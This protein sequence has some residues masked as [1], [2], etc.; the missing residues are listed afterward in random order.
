MRYWPVTL[1][2]EAQVSQRESLVR[3]QTIYVKRHAG[4][5]D[6]TIDPR[7]T[8]GINS[9]SGL[10]ADSIVSE[11][12]QANLV[13]L[14]TGSDLE[15]IVS[16]FSSDPNAVA[17]LKYLGDGGGDAPLGCEEGQHSRLLEAFIKSVAMEGLV[18][19]K[20]DMFRIH[21]SMFIAAG[22]TGSSSSPS[23]PPALLALRALLFSLEFYSSLTWLRLFFPGA[24][25]SNEKQG[26]R[27]PLVERTFVERL[28]TRLEQELQPLRELH[29]PERAMMLEYMT[30]KSTV[31]PPELARMLLI[32]K[33]PELSKVQALKTVVC[34][35]LKQSAGSAADEALIKTAIQQAHARET[36]FPSR[37]GPRLWAELIVESCRADM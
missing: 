7:G 12:G 33:S 23:P 20:I 32:L 8:K 14:A 30:G 31:V 15:S 4:R 36:F 22:H 5:M 11:R 10:D 19:D 26:H 25:H 9:R 1:N 13:S 6:Y 34:E 27:S 29:S 28:S 2:L 24:E 3:D 35:A 17:V 16:C 37:P 18:A 21:H